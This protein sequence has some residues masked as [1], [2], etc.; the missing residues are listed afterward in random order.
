PRLP[1]AARSSPA[2]WC[3]AG[4]TTRAAKA[5][6]RSR[7]RPPPAS[8]RP[9][10]YYAGR[11]TS[12]MLASASSQ[13]QQGRVITEMAAQTPP[14]WQHILHAG[15]R[16]LVQG[17]ITGLVETA[18]SALSPSIWAHGWDEGWIRAEQLG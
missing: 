15:G 13:A 2:R 18:G 5:C 4:P 10:Q 14:R 12:G 1:R 6:A 9:A 8:S 16:Q 3:W 11:L 17:T 7:P